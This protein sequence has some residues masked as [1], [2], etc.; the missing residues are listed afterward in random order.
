[1]AIRDKLSHIKSRLAQSLVLLVLT[2]ILLPTAARASSQNH[3]RL[4]FPRSEEAAVHQR[5][6][7]DPLARNL[8]K[9]LLSRA[10]QTLTL[11]VC[12]YDIPDGRRLLGQSRLALG[13]ILHCAMAWRLSH[14]KKYFER[15][16]QELDAACSL[17]DWNPSH[18]LDTAEM[19]TAVAIGYD[20]LYSDLTPIQRQT[21]ASA[22]RQKG[23][24]PA[25]E[26]LIGPEKA[27]W[28]SA[29]NNWAQVCATGHLMAERALAQPNDPIH[30]SQLVSSKILHACRKFYQPS[31]AYP[32]GPGY[33]HYGSNYHTLGLAL[34]ADAAPELQI[35]TPPEFKASTL[36][37]V[38]LTGP[39][40]LPFNFA[41]SNARKSIITPAHTWMARAFNDPSICKLIRS[42]L[43]SDIK[44]PLKRTS[45]SKDR[46]FPLHL[47]WLPKNPGQQNN[48]QLPLDSSW[49]GPQPLATF[50]SSWTDPNTLFLAIK[51]GYPAVSHGQMDIGSF[52]LESDGVRWV[53]DLGSDNYNLPEYFGY[54]RWNYLRLTNMSHNTLVI[55][56]QLQ[57]AEASPCPLTDFN[58]DS[59][60]GDATFDLSSCYLGQAKKVIRHAEFNR[61]KQH[62]TITDS[63]DGAQAPVRWAIVT[64]AKIT[65]DGQTATLR[66]AGKQLQLTRN[67]NHGGSWKVLD[68]TPKLAEENQN[69]GVR[70]LAFTAPAT[71]NLELSVTIQRP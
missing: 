38:H 2:T 66:K 1:M 60:K 69:K 8:Y 44:T 61:A 27:W 9:E 41:D 23:L 21:Y 47:L 36:F 13:N 24:E 29:R 40:G 10:D 22:L 6:K 63:I 48:Q 30:P 67:D 35:P 70:L 37:T 11:P 50:R 17:K 4:L 64:R 62:V 7:S 71:K 43:T 20:W 68:A 19:S 39:T 14:E 12:H 46:L 42:R 28:T 49:N 65:I 15:T 56:G 51:G 34:L 16:I 55:G 33:W 25:R 57:N 18:F 3:P 45:G 31:G 53:E 52:I 32:E 5:I 54:K 59:K 58:S 26:S